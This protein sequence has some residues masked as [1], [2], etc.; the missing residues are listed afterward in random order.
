MLIFH[1]QKLVVFSIPR[2]GSTSLHAALRRFAD[3]EFANPPAKKHMTVR[4]FEIWATKRRPNLLDYTRLAVMRD[5][6]ARLA[7]WYQY[8]QRDAL[9]NTD[10]STRDMT[11]DR[12]IEL[13]LTEA[14]PPSADNTG[15]QYRFLTREDGELGVQELYCIERSDVLLEHLGELFGRVKLPHR[16][17]SPDTP[18]DLSEELEARLQKARADEFALFEKLK[19]TGHLS[20]PLS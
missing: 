13:T 19:P 17:A 5:P 3:V 15:N 2:T 4:R 12:F 20:A 9:T 14:P 16:N 8:R 11:F 1:E 10:K 7:S 6:L 18:L